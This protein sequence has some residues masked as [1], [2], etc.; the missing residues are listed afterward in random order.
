MCLDNQ[1]VLLSEDGSVMQLAERM[2]EAEQIV[3][4]TYEA[5][6]GRHRLEFSDGSSVELRVA[7]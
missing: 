2:P 3:E 5:T 7:K 4:A 6:R 1:W